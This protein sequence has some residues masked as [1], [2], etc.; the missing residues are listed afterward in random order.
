MMQWCPREGDHKC[1][2]QICLLGISALNVI[3]FLWIVI[4]FTVDGGICKKTLWIS[5]TWDT[6]SSFPIST[7]FLQ[8]WNVGIHVYWSIKG[9]WAAKTWAISP[10]VHIF[11]PVA[12]C[13]GI[14]GWTKLIP[15]AL[16]LWG[17]E[18]LNYSE[19]LLGCSLLILVRETLSTGFTS[20]EI[21]GKT[22]V[23][24]VSIC[25]FQL[26]FSFPNLFMLR[27]LCEVF[28]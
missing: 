17:F 11:H 1:W 10:C 3:L 21:Q 27:Q 28:I 25:I 6:P 15:K 22:P 23:V 8:N 18:N 26:S 20:L 14:W 7:N 4:F 9:S 13:F 5:P 2:A 12:I 24:L 16:C 19:E